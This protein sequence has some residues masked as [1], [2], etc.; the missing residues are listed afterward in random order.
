MITNFMIRLVMS[1]NFYSQPHCRLLQ[2]KNFLESSMINPHIASLKLNYSVEGDGPLALQAYQIVSSPYNHI[3][4]L[5]GMCLCTKSSGASVFHSGC[6]EE[7]RLHKVAGE[8]CHM[9]GAVLKFKSVLEGPLTQTRIRQSN[10]EVLSLSQILFIA[11]NDCLHSAVVTGIIAAMMEILE[12]L[13]YD[14][15]RDASVARIFISSLVDLSLKFPPL[16][17]YSPSP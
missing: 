13:G 6:S 4:S 12:R 11:E 17:G 7:F 16:S 8:L 5:T 10:V 9:L 15:C 2:Q 14:S 3:S 1:L